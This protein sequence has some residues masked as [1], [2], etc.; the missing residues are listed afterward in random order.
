MLIQPTIFDWIQWSFLVLVVG[1]FVYLYS[2]LS[3]RPFSNYLFRAYIIKVFGGLAFACVYIYYYKFGDSFRYYHDVMKL[4]NVFITDVSQ[5]LQMMLASDGTG[6]A[7][8]VAYAMREFSFAGQAEGWFMV[9]LTSPFGLVT[10]NSYLGITF[11]MSMISLIGGWQLFKLANRLL[12]NNY[13]WSFAIAFL[14]PSTIFWGGGLLKDTY[15]LFAVSIWALAF[16]K[17]IHKEGALV[18]QL[19][20]LSVMSYI[21]YMLK[22]YILIC[23]LPWFF[24]SLYLWF[25]RSIRSKI[26][27]YVSVPV[28]IGVVATGAYFVSVSIVDSSDKYKAETLETHANGFQS[29]HKTLGGSYYDIGEIEY[30]PVGVLVASPRAL[31]VTLFRPY[32][33]EVHNV[34]MILS[35]LEGILFLGLVIWVLALARWRLWRELYRSTFLFGAFLYCIIFAVAVGMNSYNFGALVR[36]KLPMLGLFL[37]MLAFLILKFRNVKQTDTPQT[38]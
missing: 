27:K 36:Y 11:F 23:M 37:L 30:T 1:F 29:W 38:D 8:N 15:T 13:K 31:V 7:P 2:K 5:Y 33:W 12:E 17:I 6:S 25:S 28:L 24:V 35:S 10:A 22:A 26:I 20:L 3:S 9:R 14:I 4:N 21:L 19:V 18:F 16:Y 32:P 34:F